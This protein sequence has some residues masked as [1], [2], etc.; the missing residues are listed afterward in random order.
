MKDNIW[1]PQ[2]QGKS[3]YGPNGCSKITDIRWIW[4][5]VIG[6]YAGCVNPLTG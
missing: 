3:Q 1:W 4:A 5:Q 6:L 2:R